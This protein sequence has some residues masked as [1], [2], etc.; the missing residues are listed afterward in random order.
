MARILIQRAGGFGDL[1]LLT[2]VLREIKRRWPDCYIG[3]STMEHYAVAY[4]GLPFVNEIVQ[5]PVPADV[6]GKYD[7]WIFLEDAI[8]KNPRAEE[9]HM[10]DLFAEI[11][12]IDG[13]ED[14]KPAYIVSAAEAIWG[15]VAYPRT[16]APRA[17]IHVSASEMVRKYMQM[18]T[19]SSEL[20]ERGWEVM[21]LGQNGELPQLREKKM[22]PNLFN[23]TEPGI[24]FRQTA[25]VIN[26]ADVFIGADS[27]LLHVA[28]ALGVPAVGLY[29]P[30][31]W[32]LRTAYC[33]TTV[34]ISGSGDCAPCFH[35]NTANRRQQFP[36][37]CPSASKGMCQVLNSIKPNHVVAKAE[38]I[39]RTLPAPTGTGLS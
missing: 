21:L 33:P 38:K 17:A 12:G 7:A 35:H 3:V 13:I 4:A 19:V 26:N 2:P 15:N 8:E 24:T 25:A 1:I 39:A 9:V 14:K 23:L 20:V 22:P 31:L 6:A 37:H 27:S 16:K 34:A 36:A 29:G 18:G 5:F 11:V 10:T 32:K 28:G 30:F